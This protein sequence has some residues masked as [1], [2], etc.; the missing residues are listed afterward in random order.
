MEVVFWPSDGPNNVAI[1]QDGDELRV[2]SGCCQAL[3]LRVYTGPSVKWLCNSCN[4]DTGATFM[5]DV[6]NLSYATRHGAK[7]MPSGLIAHWLG[8]DPSEVRV[9][10]TWPTS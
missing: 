5:S 3:L 6:V 8:L 4:K 9:E 10:V 7:P 2:S 1:F